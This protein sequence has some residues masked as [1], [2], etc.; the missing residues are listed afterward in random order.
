[1]RALLL[2]SL[3]VCWSSVA[4]AQGRVVGKTGIPGPDLDRQ[5]AV[6]LSLREGET[7]GCTPDAGGDPD[8]GVD[9]DA[10]PGCPD[11]AVTMTVQPR[12]AFSDEGAAFAVLLATPGAPLYATESA[13]I[14]ESL[15]QITA[16]RIEEN[17]ILVEDPELG[18][19]CQVYGCGG[20]TQD[21]GCA[22][23]PNFEPPRVPDAG[24]GDGAVTVISVGPYE[25]LRLDV[26]DTAELVSWLEQ[27]EY[28][29]TQADLDAIAPYI[30]RGDVITAVRAELDPGSNLLPALTLT[31]AG[32]ELRVPVALGRPAAGETSQLTVYVAAPQRHDLGTPAPSYAAFVGID[33]SFITRTEL[34]VRD[35]ATIDT[36]P[37]ARPHADDSEVVPV[38]YVDVIVRVPV[39]DCPEEERSDGSGCCGTG[40]RLRWDAVLVACAVVL[41]IRRRRRR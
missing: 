9:P 40:R 35:T 14:F 33:P 11:A 34:T 3:I 28:A 27:F 22:A 18:T 26:A 15:A 2:G 4:V 39:T 6:L 41:S 16:P 23:T 12:F 7:V 29:Y 24:F 32:R 20:G 8:A 5:Q 36:D 21:T 13:R 10:G 17:E 30:A 31:W 25:V 19:R 38:E 1:M 37:L